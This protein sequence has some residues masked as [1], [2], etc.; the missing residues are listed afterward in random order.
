MCR[1]SDRQGRHLISVLFRQDTYLFKVDNQ[2]LPCL[3]QW[4]RDF[5]M[6]TVLIELRR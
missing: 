3:Y 2:R 4:K 6:E 1:R 5:T